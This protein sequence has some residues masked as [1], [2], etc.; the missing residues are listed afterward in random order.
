MG[1]HF[2]LM[3]QR[4]ESLCLSRR[5]LRGRNALFTGSTEAGLRRYALAGPPPGNCRTFGRQPAGSALYALDA[6]G[7][8]LLAPSPVSANTLY[9]NVR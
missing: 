1:T 8:T 7:S 9:T 6:D 4:W 5:Y 3:V 2:T